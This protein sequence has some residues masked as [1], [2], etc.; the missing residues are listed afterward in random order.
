[1]V[2]Q[3]GPNKVTVKVTHSQNQKG[4][5]NFGLYAIAFGT[6]VCYGINTSSK[7]V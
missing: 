5:T 1:M 4:S 3:C 6:A 7:I 2:F